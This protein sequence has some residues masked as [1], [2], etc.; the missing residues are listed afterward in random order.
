MRTLTQKELD[1]MCQ[2][3][4]LFLKGSPEGE[5]ADFSDCNLS[6]LN[7]VG[8]NVM[9]VSFEYSILDNCN[10]DRISADYCNFNGASLRG[11]YLHE[12]SAKEANF[13][14]ADLSGSYLDNIVCYNADFEKADLS[15]TSQFAVKASYCNFKN[16]TFDHSH[17]TAILL[18]NSNLENVSMK[19]CDVSGRADLSFANLRNANLNE[20]NLQDCNLA[21]TM[22]VNA[23]MYQ[24][25][26]FN[27]NMRQADLDSTDLSGAFNLD[28]VNMDRVQN[29]NL[30]QYNKDAAENT[31]PLTPVQQM[32]MPVYNAFYQKVTEQ[33][34]DKGRFF[35]P[36][37]HETYF[38]GRDNPL[39]Q[40]NSYMLGSGT[41]QKVENVSLSSD[42]LNRP[43]QDAILGS[44]KVQPTGENVYR[45]FDNRQNNNPILGGRDTTQQEQRKGTMT[46]SIG[47]L[48]AQKD[49][50]DNREQKNV[51]G[52]EKETPERKGDAR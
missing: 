36:L 4:D 14:N 19:H 21:N 27:A 18:A 47:D 2:K 32:Q 26:L 6:G 1:E 8:K 23:K 52:K 40:A 12:A 7:L 11:V 22:L 5:R 46:V 10:M 44:E 28:T 50:K 41:P 38:A 34:I 15:R 17:M 29:F 13:I 30:E 48:M 37:A 20:S 45:G 9:G 35:N 43:V 42:V 33:E 25:Q 51:T 49:A 3:H 24:T 31:K 16:A 39:L